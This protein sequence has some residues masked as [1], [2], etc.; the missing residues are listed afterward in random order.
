MFV[1]S[2]LSSPNPSPAQRN[3]LQ[4]GDTLV[5]I[6]GK[7]LGHHTTVEKVVKLLK[8]ARRPVR[9]QFST[10]HSRQGDPRRIEALVLDSPF[11][12]L[13]SI[14]QDMVATLGKDGLHIPSAVVA[15][16]WEKI[17]HD[18]KKRMGVESDK[19][20][21][22]ESAKNVYVPALF[23]MAKHNDYICPKSTHQVFADY[24]GPKQLEGFVGSFTDERPE[25][26]KYAVYSFF[27]SRL[28]E[29][30]AI[31]VS[32]IESK[33][34]FGRELIRFTFSTDTS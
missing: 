34:Q 5:A 21:V 17:K 13:K 2:I 11:Q 18:V 14:T 8:D 27:R 4:I 9:L 19:L 26:I 28:R 3:G 10:K 23:L 29:L 25:S 30:G 22:N 24:A 32:E 15:M 6:D 33:A 12:S 31:P 1:K 20:R 7:E 16:A